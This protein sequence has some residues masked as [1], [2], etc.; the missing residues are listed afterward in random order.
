MLNVLTCI[1]K[2]SFVDAFSRMF[3]RDSHC[4]K[5]LDSLFLYYKTCVNRR[6]PFEAVVL[7][8]CVLIN[9]GPHSKKE[10]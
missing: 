2:A 7:S 9:Y 10:R 3:N 6:I 1:E 8:H 4:V 5:R